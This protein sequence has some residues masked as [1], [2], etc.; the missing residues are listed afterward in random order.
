MSSKCSERI[1]ACFAPAPEAEVEAADEADRLLARTL[2]QDGWRPV[3]AFRPPLKTPF[4][5]LPPIDSD[6]NT[7]CEA[8]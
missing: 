8:L 1:Q 3:K 6:A 4:V 7:G 2:L 5:N